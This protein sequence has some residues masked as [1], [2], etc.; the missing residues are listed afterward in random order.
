MICS[1]TQ[2]INKRWGALV[3]MTF[4][5]LAIMCLAVYIG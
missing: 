5:N 4:K 2:E 1:I 3:C